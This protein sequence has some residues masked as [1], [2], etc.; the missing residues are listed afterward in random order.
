[1]GRSSLRRGSGPVQ[2]RGRLSRVC[3]AKNDQRGIRTRI[4]PAV[5]LVDVNVGFAKSRSRPCQLARPVWKFD[6]S[7][8]RLCDI[9]GRGPAQA[10]RG[11][12][13]KASRWEA[14]LYLL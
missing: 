12:S 9:G 11:P 13:G 14:E 3:D 2:N 8:L 7:D 5:G 10:H 6:L 1:M 4:Y